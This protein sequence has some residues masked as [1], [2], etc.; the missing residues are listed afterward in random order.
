M[1][2]GWSLILHA[3]LPLNPYGYTEVPQ[4]YYTVTVQEELRRC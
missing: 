4:G 1:E 3:T 2:H